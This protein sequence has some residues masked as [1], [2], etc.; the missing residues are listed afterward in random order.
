MLF[1]VH[2]ATLV[3]YTEQ[4]LVVE[5]D[6][7][8]GTADSMHLFPDSA[9]IRALTGGMCIHVYILLCVYILMY[10]IDT[11]KPTSRQLCILIRPLSLP[12]SDKSGIRVNAEKNKDQVVDGSNDSDDQIMKDDL[13]SSIKY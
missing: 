4:V 7:V 12:G 3:A 8:K 6:K 11:L 2:G 13:F 9:T 5:V 10:Y 1:P